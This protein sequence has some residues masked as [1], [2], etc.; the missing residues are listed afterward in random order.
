[1]EVKTDQI[2]L[3]PKKKS[4]LSF[5]I[6]GVLDATEDQMFIKMIDIF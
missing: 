3:K 6:K 1:M 4:I 2:T 5:F